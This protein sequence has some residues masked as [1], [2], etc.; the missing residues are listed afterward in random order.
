MTVD[1]FV[2]RKVQPEFRP[3]VAVIRTLIGECAPSALEA[4]SYGMPTYKRN[5]LFAWINP[6]KKDITVGFSRGTQMEDKYGL[7][8][9]V[10]KGSR[11]VRVKNLSEVNKPALRYYIKQAVK[12]DTR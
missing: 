3:I 11:H 7:L 12:L 9:G 5:K 4:I 1:E 10:A 2:E 6:T 8:R